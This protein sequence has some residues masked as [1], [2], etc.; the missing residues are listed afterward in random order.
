MVLSFSSEAEYTASLAFSLAV[1][2]TLAAYR[3]GKAS[4]L[5]PRMPAREATGCCCGWSKFDPRALRK[6]LMVVKAK[7]MASNLFRTEHNVW[8]F[9]MRVAL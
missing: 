6:W 9:Q 1:A 5:I 2:F 8:E 7:Q 3:L 4:S